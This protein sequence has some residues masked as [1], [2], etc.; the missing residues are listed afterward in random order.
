MEFH[1]LVLLL[2]DI[3]NCRRTNAVLFYQHV[4]I[5]ILLR[6]STNLNFFCFNVKTPFFF[7][8]CWFV[9]GIY[10][11]YRPNPTLTILLKEYCYWR[12]AKPRTTCGLGRL[13]NQLWELKWNHRNYTTPFEYS[14]MTI[15]TRKWKRHF[16][17]AVKF[18]AF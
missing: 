12:H 9:H 7:Q 2:T 1:Q 14:Q 11:Q 3:I 18:L 8:L 17:K 16:L 13:A 10:G 6:P 5:F 15:Q 4:P